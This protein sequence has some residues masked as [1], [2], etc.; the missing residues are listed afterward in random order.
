MTAMKV[1]GEM[2]RFLEWLQSQGLR[3]E[4]AQAV[5]DKLGIEHQKVIRVCTESDALRTEL[6][7]LAKEKFQFAMYADFCKFMNSFLKPQIVQFA[8]SPLLGG[9]FVN[10]ENV[11]RELS[12]FC[13]KFD[14]FQNV[15]LENVPSFC[16]IGFSDVCNLQLQG[17]GLTPKSGDD[18]PVNVESRQHNNS[19]VSEASIHT[20]RNE[21]SHVHLRNASPTR[22]A[23]E[24]SRSS[25]GQIRSR[26]RAAARMSCLKKQSREQVPRRLTSK[27]MSG[28]CNTKINTRSNKR[29]TILETQMRYKCNI[30]NVDFTSS[31]NVKIHMRIHT[32]ER[33]HKCSVCDKDF[34][35]KGTLNMHMRIHTGERPY[36]CSRCNKSFPRKSC[37]K[38]HM[39]IHT[40]ERPY[41]CSRCNKS[42]FQK[43]DLNQHMR[44]HTGERPYKCS[45]CN[46]SFPRKRCL[47]IHMMIHTGERP[48]KCCIC[49]K[50]FPQI[51]D[52][53]KHARVHTRERPYK[54]SICNKS[55]PRKDCLKIHMRVHT[56]ERPY[57]CSICDKSFSQ[58]SH[59]KKH[60]RTHT[61]E[62]K[63]IQKK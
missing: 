2:E 33:P 24:Q 21:D 47:E 34:S 54:C 58:N 11:I 18:S 8:G 52:L 30:C 31:S 61:R 62:H 5:I 25:I 63:K 15:Q 49:N 46:K 1:M 14:G 32:G 35:E 12:S 39:R 19:S 50:S 26:C 41:K 42:F 37:L 9:L 3:A 22:S 23:T 28:P 51:N 45:I 55:F 20:S 7:S 43:F 48:H 27:C 44:I 59:L 13:K 57:K 10:L 29:K 40:G 6:L 60:M 56:G 16:G 36:K 38:I 53:N 17:D 4:T